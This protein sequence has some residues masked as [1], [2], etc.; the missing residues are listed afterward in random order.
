[1][2]RFI[3]LFLILSSCKKEVFYYPSNSFF[4]EYKPTKII[5]DDLSFQEITDT[6]RKGLYRKEKYFIELEDTDFKYKISPFADTGGYLKERNGLNIKNDSLD[7]IN[8]VFS[9]S[10]LSKFLKL[11]Y[12]NNDKEH[13]YAFS[14]KRAYIRL[15]LDREDSSQKLKNRLLNLV[16]VYNKTDIIHKDSIEL[17]I[18]FDYPL[19]PVS[20]IPPPPSSNE[21]IE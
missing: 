7:L 19:N 4:E 10:A 17:A 21:I 13:Y 16:K 14:H 9:I 12:E 11:H 2:K 18:M 15:T 3:I 8:G 6:I 5:I 1:M 20:S